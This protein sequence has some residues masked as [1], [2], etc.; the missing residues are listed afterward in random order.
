MNARDKARLTVEI[1]EVFILVDARLLVDG[2]ADGRTRRNARL[3][4]LL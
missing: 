1:V 3:P 2:H 4:Y